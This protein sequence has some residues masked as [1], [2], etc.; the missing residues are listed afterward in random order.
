[1]ALAIA[2]LDPS[3]ETLEWSGRVGTGR[4][5][6]G[7]RI[8]GKISTGCTSP[9]TLKVDCYA[10][11]VFAD[12]KLFLFGSSKNGFGFRNSDM[13]ICMTLGNRTKEEVNYFLLLVLAFIQLTRSSTQPPLDFLDSFLEV[14][15][16]RQQ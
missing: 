1:M 6:T 13:D 3:S 5:E 12:A 7:R 8:K 10:S 15:L 9:G 16:A 11:F 14:V 2:L 4:V